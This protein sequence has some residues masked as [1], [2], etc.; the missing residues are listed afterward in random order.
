MNAGQTLDDAIDLHAYADDAEDDDADLTF[1]VVSSLPTGL[2]V[3][4]DGNRYV[5]IT[6]TVGF[7]GA[8]PVE[9]QVED[10]GGLTASDAFTV[11]A[12]TAPTLT[13]LPD[14]V[15]STAGWDHAIDLWAY[16]GDTEDDVAALTFSIASQTPMSVGASID[17]NRYVDIQPL[18]GYTGTAQVQVQV[19]DT[20]D[21]TA[22]DTF[23]VEVTDANIP[24]ELAL[25]DVTMEVSQT[26]SI[27]LWPY[28]TDRNDPKETLTFTVRGVSDESLIATI[29]DPDAHY[30][31]L[32]PSAGWMGT[33]RVEI[34]VEDPAGAIVT[35]TTEVTVTP[36]NTAPTLS[37]LPDQT[38]RAGQTEDNA[39]DLWAYAADAEDADADL[40]FS[41]LGSPPADAGV[42]IDTNRYIDISPDAS[43][44]GTVAIEVQVQDTGSLTATDTF[45]LT[46]QPGGLIYLPLVTKNWPPIPATPALHAID[47]AD[48]DG[49]YTVNWGEATLADTYILQE[50]DNTAFSSPQE[51]YNSSGLSWTAMG[52]SAGAYYYRV[53]AHNSWG[54]SGWSTVQA[55]FVAPDTFYA[56][57][58]ASALQ[59]APNLNDGSD[60]TMWV[61][62]DHCPDSINGVNRGLVKFDVSSIPAGMPI[63]SAT[64]HLYLAGSCDLDNRTHTVTSYRI[65]NNWTEGTVT[66][67]TQPSIAEAH[68]SGTVASQSWGWYTLDVTGLVRGWANQ[69][70][71]NYGLM[72]RGPEGSGNDSARLSFA[73]S[74]ASGYEPYITVNYGGVSMTSQPEQDA[75]PPMLDFSNNVK[76]A[77]TCGSPGASGFVEM[78]WCA[79]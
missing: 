62:Y 74:E 70:Y 31:Y 11:T 66:W 1:S 45:T 65:T 17:A 25:E 77:P 15:V 79:E 13:G 8:A 29:V 33:A 57:E 64:L 73:T 27:D 78:S 68:G 5:D 38:V 58:D 54:D 6:A 23:E 21:L 36:A 4:I 34:G 51:V 69:H 18:S 24:P 9:I 10:T 48:G 14:Q 71:P 19:I 44:E 20:G 61:G 75:S 41:L 42:S 59:G 56:V 50:D 55:A 76:G 16:A 32:E 67:N 63:D 53:K 47:N 3:Q 43:Y 7:A 35:D 30:L 2:D 72:L 49:A 39:I 60:L 12:N 22:T 37:G 52:K 26:R 28:V 46:V 40:T